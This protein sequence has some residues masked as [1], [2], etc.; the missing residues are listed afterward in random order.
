MTVSQL[1]EK[2]RELPDPDNIHVFRG[3]ADNYGI[4]I[5]TVSDLDGAY[6]DERGNW[7]SGRSL[8]PKFETEIGKGIVLD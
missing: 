7:W 2:L 4:S 3:D 5:D 1:I 6:K 8:Y